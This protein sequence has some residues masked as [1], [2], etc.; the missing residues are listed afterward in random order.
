MDIWQKQIDV[1]HEIVN[2]CLYLC[3]Y[4]MYVVAKDGLLPRTQS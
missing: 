4:Y 1:E 2:V 3:I